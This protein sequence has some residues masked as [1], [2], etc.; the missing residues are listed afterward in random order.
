MNIFKGFEQ[1][2][3]GFE[4][5]LNRMTLNKCV[6]LSGQ[7][8]TCKAGLSPLTTSASLS[9]NGLYIKKKACRPERSETES[10]GS[11]LLVHRH[12][13]LCCKCLLYMVARFY[14]WDSSTSLGMTQGIIYFIRFHIS[15]Y[16]IPRFR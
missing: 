9:S 5:Y 7:V 2:L 1:V 12:S 13:I 11:H 14:L 10:N 4:H 16:G 6:A 8:C 15:A 3:N